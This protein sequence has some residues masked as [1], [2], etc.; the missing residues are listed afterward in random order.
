[1]SSSWNASL[2][3]SR[4]WT[5]P[6]SAYVVAYCSGSKSKTRITGRMVGIPGRRVQSSWTKVSS[7]APRG[8][9]DRVGAGVDEHVAPSQRGGDRAERPRAREAVQAPAAGPRA[10]LHEAAQQ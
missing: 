5:Q 1:M 4:M 7:E 3:P 6:W 2:T 10:R 9:R 8:D